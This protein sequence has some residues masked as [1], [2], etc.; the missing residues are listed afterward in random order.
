MD[1]HSRPISY[2]Q[3]LNPFSFPSD[4]TLRFILLIVSIIGASLFAYYVLFTPLALFQDR[5]LALWMIGGVTV[6]LGVA[7]LIYWL[8]P[9]WKIW[10]RELEPLGA[11]DMPELVSYLDDLC[12]EVEL[13]RPPI[14][15]LNPLNPAPSGLAFGRLGWYYSGL[16]SR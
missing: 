12:H 1:T 5:T 8:S 3:R 2:G 16:Q 4:T 15:K 11:E 14:Y 13:S 10:R 6:L 9:T 7:A